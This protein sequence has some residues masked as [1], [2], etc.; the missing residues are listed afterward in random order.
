MQY[1]QCKMLHRS[2]SLRRQAALS[3][4]PLAGKLR[5]A[6]IASAVAGIKQTNTKMV[7]KLDGPTDVTD[8]LE[9]LNVKY[10]KVIKPAPLLTNPCRSLEHWLTLAVEDI[11]IMIQTTHY[12]AVPLAHAAP[13]PPRLT[14]AATLIRV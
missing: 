7:E 14:L 2:H 5:I 10:E 8:F 6:H 3:A 13:L 12:Y 9:D 4:Q 1:K 11:A